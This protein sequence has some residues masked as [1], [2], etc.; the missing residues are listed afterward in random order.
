M[1]GETG[2][3]PN[4]PSEI[5]TYDEKICDI[6]EIRQLIEEDENLFQTF[7]DL[8]DVKDKQAEMQAIRRLLVESKDQ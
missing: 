7:E 4:F 1:A 2:F 5:L 3:V 8:E 6:H